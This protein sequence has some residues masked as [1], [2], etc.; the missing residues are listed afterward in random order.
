MDEFLD[1]FAVLKT[2]YAYI[3]LRIILHILVFIK[4]LKSIFNIFTLIS[5]MKQIVNFM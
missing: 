4:N 2:T 5:K 3:P 1:E